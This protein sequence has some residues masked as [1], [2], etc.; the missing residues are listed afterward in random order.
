[1]TGTGPEG[2]SVNEGTKLAFAPSFEE[3][4]KFVKSTPAYQSGKIMLLPKLD[5]EGNDIVRSI[6]DL[7]MVDKDLYQRFANQNSKDGTIDASLHNTFVDGLGTRLKPGFIGSL[8]HGALPAVGSIGGLGVGTLLG[9]GGGNPATVALGSVGGA[10]VGSGLGE[11]AN[12]QIGNKIYNTDMPTRWGDVGKQ[13]A[14]GA[15]TEGLS[16][17]AA[18]MATALPETVKGISVRPQVEGLGEIMARKLGKVETTPIGDEAVNVT[19]ITRGT[20]IQEEAELARVNSPIKKVFQ[21]AQEELEAAKRQIADPSNNASLEFGDVHGPLSREASA[22][23]LAIEDLPLGAMDD[24]DLASSGS[25]SNADL[26]AELKAEFPR[27]FSDMTDEQ[28]LSKLNDP[29]FF[30]DILKS[31]RNR[32]QGGRAS[33]LSFEDILGLKPRQLIMLREMAAKRGRGSL[34]SPETS[35]ALEQLSGELGD[36]QAKMSRSMGKNRLKY[37]SESQPGYLDPKNYTQRGFELGAGLLNASPISPSQLLY[38]R[39]SK[40]SSS[41]KKN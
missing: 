11:Y 16:R 13:A 6:D 34:I 21:N 5:S 14:L 40:S 19:K 36:L 12:Q 23:P 15:V 32:F 41:P 27:Q 35:S 29:D 22:S 20:P 3:A 1:M 25:M 4:L 10:G 28:I 37:G 7:Y 8:V 26:V 17:L 24:V 9:L 39:L 31:L 38:E 33:G 18:P 2:L 30:T